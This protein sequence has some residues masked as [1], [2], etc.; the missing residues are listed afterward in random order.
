MKKL[1]KEINDDGII[2]E[3]IFPEFH[4]VAFTGD[5]DSLINKPDAQLPSFSGDYNDL[6][7]KP[8][9]FDGNYNS[10]TDKPTLF[11]GDYNTLTNKP[12]LFDGNYNN[13]TNKP[14]LFDGNY[15]TLTN[16]PSLFDGN[17]NSL[18]NKP[19]LFDGDYNKLTNKPTSKVETIAAVSHVIVNTNKNNILKLTNTGDVVVTV[20]KDLAFIDAELVYFV[21]ISAKSV[22]FAPATGVIIRSEDSAL[23]MAKQNTLV[24]LTKIGVNE[25]LLT[26]NI[27][28]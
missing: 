25:Y 23:K 22:R 9:L 5:Y 18:I 7:N 27:I 24:A 6:T 19:V 3:K 12:T 28:K 10:L 4:P 1:I 2:Q 21:N 16:K 13:L 11:D 20:A 26:G 17:Y 15:N 8:A 14:S